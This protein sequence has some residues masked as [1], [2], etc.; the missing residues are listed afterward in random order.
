MKKLSLFFITALLIIGACSKDQKTVNRLEG[1]W[2]ITE[3]TVDGVAEPDSSYRDA[4]YSF[5]KCKVKKTSCDGT[6]TEDG[7]ALPFTY[8]ITDKGTKIT[9][10]FLGI[11]STGDIIENS[12]T[13]F[14]WKFV[15]DNEETITTIEKK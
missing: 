8:K 7:K 9:M 14:K 5:E 6:F 1:D 13:K 2:K 10:T 12:K 15:E 3:V 4:T 11:Q